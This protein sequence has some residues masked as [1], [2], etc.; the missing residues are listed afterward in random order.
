MSLNIDLHCHSIHSD[1]TWIVESLLHEAERR[2]IQGYAITDH[3]TLA[4]S[5]EAFH[6]N[7]EKQIF[8]GKLLAGTEIST[9]VEGLEIHLIALFSTL[10]NLPPKT[11]LVIN[12]DRMQEDR[13]RRMKEMVEKV[14]AQ[15]M[16]VE[17]HEVVSEAQKGMKSDSHPETILA[18]PHLARILVEKGYVNSFEEAFDLYLGNDQPCYVS[19]FSLECGE[20][21]R[22]IKKHGGLSIWAHPLMGAS[23]NWETWTKIAPRLIDYQINGFEKN[24]ILEGVEVTPSTITALQ[25]LDNKFNSEDLL[26][27]TGGDYHGDRGT[28]GETT[29]SEDEWD[30]ILSSFGK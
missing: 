16:K 3:D 5:I 22:L 11:E 21:I 14:C 10:D 18:R 7:R 17:Y 19:K 26:I 13:V 23:N 6:L 28:L 27:S 30:R 2:K 1:G 9:H 24:K 15:G 20:W 25:Y 12:L 29:L 4:G 8:R